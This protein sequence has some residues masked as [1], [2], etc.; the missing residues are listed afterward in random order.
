M[1]GQVFFLE[2][3]DYEN[4]FITQESKINEDNNVKSDGIADDGDLFLGVHAMDFKLPCVSQ[5][6]SSQS[7]VYSDISDAE[8]IEDF[9]IPSSQKR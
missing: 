8:D 5:L 3:D 4:M 1:E 7:A 9:E 6:T 2:D